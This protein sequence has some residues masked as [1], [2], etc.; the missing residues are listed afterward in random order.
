M[1]L[2]QR[3]KR[4]EE[5]LESTKIE[6]DVCNCEARKNAEE[7]YY[8]ESIA[9]DSHSFAENETEIESMDFICGFCQ[10]RLSEAEIEFYKKAQMGFSKLQNG[11]L[12]K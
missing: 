6:S 2:K 4:I 1:Q 11:E 9:D 3:I 12:R 10:K 7:T 5:K 8:N